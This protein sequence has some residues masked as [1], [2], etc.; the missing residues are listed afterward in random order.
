MILTKIIEIEFKKTEI[1]KN[2]MQLQKMKIKKNQKSLEIKIIKLKIK[3]NDRYKK[4]IRVR[5]T[6]KKG[7]NLL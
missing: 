2:N 1:M 6:V 7:M 5:T 4:K 3:K